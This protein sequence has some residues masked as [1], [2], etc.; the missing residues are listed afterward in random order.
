[1]HGKRNPIAFEAIP[2]TKLKTAYISPT[3]MAIPIV[4]PNKNKEYT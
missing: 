4:T 1:M 3:P 2:P